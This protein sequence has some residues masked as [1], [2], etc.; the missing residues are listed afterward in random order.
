M[1]SWLA[2][3]Y[4]LFYNTLFSV[5]S[6]FQTVNDIEYVFF[7]LR[8]VTFLVIPGYSKKRLVLLNALGDCISQRKRFFSQNLGS[9][10]S[11]SC[12][13]RRSFSFLI[14]FQSG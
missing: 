3:N 9:T 8:W 13:L 11:V 7:T 6:S 2:N 14:R 12:C 1:M 5:I 10:K 4:F